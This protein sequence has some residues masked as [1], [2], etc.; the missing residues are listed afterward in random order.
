MNTIN[1]TKAPRFTAIFVNGT[2]AVRDSVGF[3]HRATRGAGQAE[4]LARVCNAAGR[5][6]FGGAGGAKGGRNDN[7]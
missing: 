1:N 5:F 3:T 6:T 4:A 7:R 2:Y